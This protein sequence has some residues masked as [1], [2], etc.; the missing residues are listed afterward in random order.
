MGDSD[1]KIIFPAGV[2]PY[3]AR[4]IVTDV[5]VAEQDASGRL[6][7]DVQTFTSSCA[8]TLKPYQEAWQA[9]TSARLEPSNNPEPSTS[10][11]SL[12]AKIEVAARAAD[13]ACSVQGWQWKRKE[14]QKMPPEAVVDQIETGARMLDG[15]DG[16]LYLRVALQAAEADKK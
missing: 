14:T 5:K 9:K 7:G 12:D 11:E 1:S 13:K 10:R 4:N 2:V 15:A 8:E 6:T 16:E 3:G